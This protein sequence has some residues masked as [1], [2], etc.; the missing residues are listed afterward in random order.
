MGKENKKIDRIKSIF[1]DGSETRNEAQMLTRDLLTLLQDAM[2]TSGNTK[3]SRAVAIG[4]AAWTVGTACKG[5]YKLYKRTND[6]ATFVIKI[7]EDEDIF[8]IVENWLMDALPEE[9]QRS[10]YAISEVT[11]RPKKERGKSQ[12]GISLIE[13]LDDDIAFEN[14]PFA[15]DRVAIDYSFDGE[16]LQ[17]LTIAGHEVEIYTTVP[18]H[19]MTSTDGGRNTSWNMRSINIECPNLEARNAVLDEIENQAQHLIRSQPRMFITSKWG[20]WRR[21]SEIQPRSRDSVIL[22]EGQMERILDY[23]KGFLNNREAFDKV[24]IPYR[25][26]ILLYGDPGSGKSSTALAI[27]NELRM[28]VYIVSLTSLLNDDALNDAFAGI[29]ANSIVVLEDI[30]ITAAVRDRDKDDDGVTMT[31][32]LN[33]LDDFQSPPGVIT[34]MTTNR[35]DVLDKAIIR[36]GRVDLQ[37]E[38][39]CLDTHQ[40]RGL[41]NYFMGYIPENLPEITAEDGISSAEIMGEVRKHLPNFE[42]AGPDIIKFIKKKKR[43][44][45]KKKSK[46][47]NNVVPLQVVA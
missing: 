8:E 44:L 30:D 43:K 27:A 1:K 37:E 6:A 2:L 10:V 25:T 15:K 16:V 45:A 33:V 47:Q 38:L 17:K 24:D 23:L 9:E 42:N 36:P 22:K 12:P 5:L 3:L 19:R 31:G 34:I 29:P 46:E 35:K 20:D 28:N 13:E 40:L 32:M 39:G 14:N 21:R 26:G 41:C 4:S 18:E 11:K 7:T